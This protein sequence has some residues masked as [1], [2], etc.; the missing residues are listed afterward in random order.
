MHEKNNNV[1]PMLNLWFDFT[2]LELNS[3]DFDNKFKK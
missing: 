2:Y 1:L 3:L